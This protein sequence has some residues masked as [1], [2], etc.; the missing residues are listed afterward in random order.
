MLEGERFV[1]PISSED[2]QA[3]VFDAEAVGSGRRS[4]QYSFPSFSEQCDDCVYSS[5][6]I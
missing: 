5:G 3:S 6:V 2:V 1:F 4:R